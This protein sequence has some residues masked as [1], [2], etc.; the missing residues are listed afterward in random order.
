[1][2]VDAK[3]VEM[4]MVNGEWVKVQDYERDPDVDKTRHWAIPMIQRAEEVMRDEKQL[5]SLLKSPRRAEI[6]NM[7]VEKGLIKTN[8]ELQSAT[9]PEPQS[10]PNPSE[11]QPAVVEDGQGESPHVPSRLWLCALIPLCALPI[12]YFLR[13]KKR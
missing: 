10:S 13:R 1:M 2:K 4:W 3:D 9:A 6:W 12:F 5:A 8:A 11:N 7:L